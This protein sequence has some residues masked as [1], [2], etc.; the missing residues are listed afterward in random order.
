MKTYWK[1]HTKEYMKSVNFTC[2]FKGFKVV[3]VQK[4]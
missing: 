3:Q 4:Q 1:A 2:V